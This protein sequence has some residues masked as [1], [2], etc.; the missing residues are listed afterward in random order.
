MLSNSLRN[1]TSLGEIISPKFSCK[2]N[3]SIPARPM[4]G[5]GQSYLNIAFFSYV[6]FPA[7][8]S[9]KIVLIIL[10]VAAIFSIACV[11]AI[12]ACKLGICP[13]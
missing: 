4:T 1:S 13:S 5:I 2:V 3:N 12:I 11:D 7:S 10:F 8:S 9:S 6:P